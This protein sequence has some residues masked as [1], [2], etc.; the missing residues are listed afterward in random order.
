[1]NADIVTKG[2]SIKTPIVFK[3]AKATT[4]ILTGLISFLFFKIIHIIV[5]FAIIPAINRNMQ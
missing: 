3:I 1:M 4:N 2:S 5:G